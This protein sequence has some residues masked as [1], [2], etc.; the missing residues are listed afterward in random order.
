[1]KTDKKKHRRNSRTVCNLDWRI[2]YISTTREEINNQITTYF[3]RRRRRRNWFSTCLCEHDEKETN[4]KY[5]QP[6]ERWR[7]SAV[8]WSDGNDD[9]GG[10][11]E[12]REIR[13]AFEFWRISMH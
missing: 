3:F 2:N 11:E 12:D 6:R 13:I 5:H 9:G 10:G 8:L 7:E 4:Q 1:M